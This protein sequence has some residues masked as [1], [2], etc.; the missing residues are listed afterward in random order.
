LYLISLL[1]LCSLPEYELSVDSILLEQLYLDPLAALEI[2]AVL[3]LEGVSGDCTVAFRGGSSLWCC[4]KSW[5][6]TVDD[7]SLFPFGRN[8]LLNAQFR[9]ASVMRNTLGLYLTGTLGYP[10]PLT[11]YCTLTINGKNMGVYE[12]VEAIDRVFYERNGL[13]F[14]PLYKSVNIAGRLSHQYS[15]TPETAGYEPKADSSPYSNQL[16]QL[17][18][19]CF[20]GDISSLET[21]EILAAFAVMVAI[22]D[23]DA[24]SCNYYLHKS[25]ETWHY[26]PWD[27]DASFGNSWQGVYDSLWTHNS[28]RGL[29]SIFGPA[30]AILSVPENRQTFNELLCETAEIFSSDLCGVVDSLERLIRDDLASDPYYKYT[31][32]QFDSVCLVLK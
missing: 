30:R 12:R 24:V 32:A 14:G 17:I 31:T 10:A 13:L 3:S 20:R 26:Y 25:R 6:I 8:A 9:D 4:K 21:N 1:V 15:D 18:E 16:A 22:G 23:R 29:M 27:R 2:L 7:S 19:D 28:D 11:E 5:H